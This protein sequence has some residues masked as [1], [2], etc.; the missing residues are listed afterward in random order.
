MYD[1]RPSTGLQGWIDGP[2][3]A[4]A[5]LGPTV[6]RRSLDCYAPRAEPVPGPSTIARRSTLMKR[7]FKQYEMEGFFDEMFD[8]QQAVRPHYRKLVDRFTQ[9][10][11]AELAQRQ[12][13]AELAFLNQGITFTVY[14][15]NQGT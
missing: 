7:P 12:L 9:L 8:G 1:R 14:N 5:G 2:N 13:M 11:G 6:D 3:A 15:D 10:L 4:N